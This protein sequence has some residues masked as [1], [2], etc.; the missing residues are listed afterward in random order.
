MACFL[1]DRF[2][3]RLVDVR[4]ALSKRWLRN[5]VQMSMK[6]RRTITLRADRD[7]VFE[8]IMLSDAPISFG[9][10][11]IPAAVGTLVVMRLK[12]A[13][14]S[15]R[16]LPLRFHDD[17]SK[18]GCVATTGSERPNCLSNLRSSPRGTSAR[19]RGSRK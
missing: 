15:F 17:Q 6:I 16:V 7:R 12:A 18:F 10:G 19:I 14:F 9:S 4:N 8:S 11:D 5:L 3:L 13:L 2:D 1:I